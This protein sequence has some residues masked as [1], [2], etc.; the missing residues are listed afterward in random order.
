MQPTAVKERDPAAPRGDGDALL[1]TL[2]TPAMRQFRRFKEAHPGCLLFFRM[3]DFYELFGEDAVQAHRALGITLTERT[4]G[5]PMAGVPFHAAEPY[6]RK[7]VEQGFRVAVCDQI[8]DPKDAKGVVDRAVTRVVTPGT[9]VDEHLLDD[10]RSNLVAAVSVGTAPTAGGDPPAAIALIELSTGAFHLHEVAASE[11][12]D[13]LDRLAPQELLVAAD[14]AGAPPP[15]VAPIATAL[16]CPP[17]LRPGWTFAPEDAESRLREHFGVASLAGFG[18]DAATPVAAAAGALLRYVEEIS[19]GDAS[20]RRIAHLQPPRRAVRAGILEVDAVA[21]RALE[22]E[23]TARSGGS[24]G[25]LLELMQRGRTPMGRRLLREWLCFPLQDLGAIRSRHRRVALLCEDRTLADRVREALARIQD[26]ARIGGRLGLGRATPRDLAALARSIEH[27][28]RLCDELDS[29]AAFA[30]SAE[31]LAAGLAEVEALAQRC[32]AAIVE[33]PPSHLRDGGAIAD[34]VDAALDEARGLSRDGAAW[35][36]RHQAELAEQ[37]GI[38]SLKIGFN[39]VF[40]YYI[41]ITNAHRERIPAGFERRQTLKNAERYVTAT[42]L[43]FEEK[44]LTAES[45]ALER[46]RVL[47]DELSAAWR[48]HLGALAKLGEAIAEL[49]VLAGFA[50]VASEYHWVEPEMDEAPRLEVEQGRHPVLDRLLRDRF[51]PNDAHLGAVERADE[52]VGDGAAAS[53]ALITGPNMAGKST[54]IRQVALLVLLAHAGSFVPAARAR[55]GRCDRI[56]TRIGAADELHAGQSTFMVEMSETANLLRHATARSVVVLDEI[57]RG[58]STLD[59]LSL[60]WGIAEALAERGCRTLLATHY[61]ELTELAMRHPA[62]RNLHVAVREWGDRIVFLHR[63]EQ[64]RTDRSYGIHVARLA[65][66]PEAV[67]ARAQEI[68]GSLEVRSTAEAAAIDAPPAPRQRSHAAAAQAS[69]FDAP[70][71]PAWLGEF[72]QLDLD[73][74]TPL[75]AFDLLRRWKSKA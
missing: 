48:P 38:P 74:T 33:H 69:L 47:F 58:T 63:I 43:E 73:A 55:I 8:Q 17:T 30:E 14:P 5:V 68:L 70:A 67:V 31:A 41:E 19:A 54:Y 6:L 75:Q 28:R 35:L 39:R 10:A 45:R 56:F 1:A 7:L 18:I 4:K 29:V 2:D 21:L 3:G 51:V 53:L 66:V 49:D 25:T 27:A 36:A 46:E 40:G 11:L 23:R 32:S 24:S 15:W 71:E 59:G 52:G 44:V 61:H 16:P 13:R 62:V 72:R 64:G 12:A 50:E 42:L 22:V 57:G 9:L 60:A 37:S 65:G 26:L 34:G 20:G